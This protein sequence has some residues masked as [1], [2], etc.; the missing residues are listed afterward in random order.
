MIFKNLLKLI[1]ISVVSALMAFTAQAADIENGKVI[2]QQCSICHNSAKDGSAKVGPNLWGIV[3]RA[4]ASDDDYK[5]RYSAAL[6][7]VGGKW[8]ADQISRFVE[9]PQ[10]FANGTYMG[11]A[12][13]ASAQDRADLI[14]YLN[15]QSDAPIDY[16]LSEDPQT[17]K[18]AGPANIGKL[19]RAPGAEK[20]FIYCSACHSERIVTQQGL[21]KSDWQ[22]LLEWMVDE[23]G[24]DE[25]EEPD[26]SAVIEYLSTNYGTDRPNFPTKN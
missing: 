3:N 14:A 15:S 19:F 22:E 1:S 21:T 17:S 4:I 20:T 24:M 12:G 25:I 11:F 6:Q 23:Q 2:F 18:T 7:G 26:Y 13:L 10:S 9:S 8:S 5:G 16:Q